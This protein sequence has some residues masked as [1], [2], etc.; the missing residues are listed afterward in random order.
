MKVAAIIESRM[1]STRLPGKNLK[2]ILGRPMLSRLL[3]RLK[4]S[5]LIDVI[6]LATSVD[7]ADA[8]LEELAGGEGL[9]C[10]RGSLE[11]VLHRTLGAANSVGADVI[12]EITGD[13][14]LID[15]AI[16]D[17]AIRRYKKQDVDYV[18]N[19]LDRLS[20]PIGFDVQVYST[21][22]L[23]EVDGLATEEYDR[24]NVT[25]Y[26]Y[27]HPERYRLLNLLAPPELDRPRYRLCVD[28]VDDF[29]LVT[30][31]FETLYP[32]DSGFTAFDIV[33]FLDE[34]PVLAQSNIGRDDAFE[35]PSSGDQ[36]RQEVVTFNGD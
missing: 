12:V 9:A 19:V 13:C 14:P 8:P 15:P 35:F 1:S 27:H 26:V 2:P 22:L 21:A 4:R 34:N 36:A 16:I 24:A 6:C 25:P 11:D 30:T 23:S 33:R 7:P 32:A 5:R 31:I 17:A 28:Y 20:F 10:Y 18:C 3:E 29:N